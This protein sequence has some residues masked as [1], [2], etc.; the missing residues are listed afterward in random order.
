MSTDILSDVLRAVRLTGA[1]FFDV[2]TAA[3]WVAEAP[4][5]R[6]IAPHVMP[7]APHVI[8]YHVVVAGTCYGGLIGEP[9]V[10]LEPGSIIAFPQGDPHVLSSAPGMRGRPELQAY[11]RSAGA[12]LPI[13][14][15]E[16]GDGPV[17]GHVVCGFLGCDVRPFNPL[18][19]ALPR[20][21]HVPA[22]SGASLEQLIRLAVDESAARRSGGECVLARLSEL[23][24]VEV[25]RR[26]LATLPPDQTGWLGALRDAPVGRALTLFHDR[27]QHPWTLDELADEVGLSRTSLAERFTHLVGTSPIQY[28]AHWRMQLA[29]NLLATGSNSVAEVAFAV[30]YGSEAAFSRA[31]KRLVGAAPANWR[32]ARSPWADPRAG[33]SATPSSG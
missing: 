6:V 28:L 11:Q 14:I 18:I 22:S 5:A 30:G 3:P 2:H 10:H 24:F 19:A 32:Q 29:A 8:E 1:I 12:Q 4:P 9:P 31:F 21:I 25:V 16:G 13:V 27:P 33:G 26:H 23:L 7:G 17:R 20:M 15:K